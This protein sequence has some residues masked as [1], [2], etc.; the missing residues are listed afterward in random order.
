MKVRKFYIRIAPPSMGKLV[1]LHTK[2]VWCCLAN[3]RLNKES[4]TYYR[5]LT[6]REAY[7]AILRDVIRTYKK[8][9]KRDS[10]IDTVN[11]WGS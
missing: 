9:R 7:R 5:S 3:F 2:G 8:Q 4:E 11:N 10:W 1:S 6:T